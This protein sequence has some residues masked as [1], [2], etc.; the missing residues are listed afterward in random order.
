METENLIIRSFAAEDLQD[1]IALIRD[2]MQSPYAVYD[3]QF[4]IDDASLKGLLSYFAASDEFFA[5]WLKAEARVIGFA[6]LN[7]V[8]DTSRNLGY[9]I[10]TDYQGKGYAAE[11][12]MEMK[13]YAKE[14]LKLSR[15]ISGTAEENEPSFRLLTRAGFCITGKSQGSFAK[16]ENGNPIIFTGCLFECELV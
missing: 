11:A 1:F 9:C 4:P 16:D 3:E 14:T 8:D 7:R 15:L 2:K 10:H 6:S 12:V 5:V 13:R